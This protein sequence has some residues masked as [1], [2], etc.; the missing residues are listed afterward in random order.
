MT[1]LIFSDSHGHPQNMIDAIAAEPG[2]DACIFLGDG[3]RQF[4]ALAP[5][6]PKMPLYGVQ[7]NCDGASFEPEE[8]LAP[9]GGVLFFY[10]HGHS[11][12]VKR[13]LDALWQA[14]RRKGAAAAL[15]GHTHIPYYEL[16]GGIHLFNPGS[17]AQPRAGAPS[18]GRITV[19][20]GVPEFVHCR[21]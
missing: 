19:E 20:D 1:L 3:V 9:F 14:A 10:T 2:A 4:A 15:F 21:V 13:G 16:R 17:I 11:Y 12:G 6:F 18:Y 5:V 8:G 7:G